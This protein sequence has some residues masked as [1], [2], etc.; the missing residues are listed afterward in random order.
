M[1]F[2]PRIGR[3]AWSKSLLKAK[4]YLPEPVS[5]GEAAVL[6]W[7][8]QILYLM[9]YTNDSWAKL[10][11]VCDIIVAVPFETSPFLKQ[12]TGNFSSSQAC[13]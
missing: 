12:R 6:Q 2:L 5:E 3:K 11:P 7:T 13:K 8:M 9:F 4:G 1:E 10:Q